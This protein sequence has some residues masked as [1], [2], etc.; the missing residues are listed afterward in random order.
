MGGDNQNRQRMRR[1]SGESSISG[2]IMEINDVN[3][4]LTIK[5]NGSKIIFYSD[6]T[7]VFFMPTSTPPGFSPHGPTSTASGTEAGS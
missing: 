4:V 5:D 6:K 7:Q 3:I 1:Q 2:E